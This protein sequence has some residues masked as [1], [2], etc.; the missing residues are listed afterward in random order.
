MSLVNELFQNIRFLK[1]YGWESRWSSNAQ[2][3]RNTELNW[4]IKSYAID[5]MTSFLWTRIPA[6]TT[7]VCFWSYTLL[8]GQ[9]L[10]VSKAF[11]AMALFSSLQGPMTQ[12][13]G[14]VMALING[15]YQHV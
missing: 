6:I 8:E 11:T 15:K 3:A 4:R 13:P 14:Q 10:T 5:T 7:L 9:T 12:L 1:F 2:G